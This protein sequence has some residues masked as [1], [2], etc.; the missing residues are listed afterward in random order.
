MSSGL[1]VFI[2][3]SKDL[4]SA[5][6]RVQFA[7]SLGVD[8][9]FSTHIASRDGLMTL[10]A[11]AA[12]TSTIKLGTGVLP[13]F[14]RHP[15]SLAVEAATLDEISGGRLILGVGPSHKVTME[16]WYGIPLDR[17]FSQMREYVDVLRQVFT[18]GRAALDGEFYKVQYAFM[19]YS[20]RPDIPIYLS[21]L[22]PKMLAFVGEACEGTI[23]WSCM[24]PY[25]RSTVAPMIAGAAAKA[26]RGTPD[27]I[28]AIPTALTTNKAAAFEQLRGDFFVYMTLPFYRR[29]IA[30]SGFQD[31]I[32]A[33]DKALGSGDAP[34]AKTAMSDEMLE[35]FAAIGDAK[36]IA[37]KIGEYRD[38]GVT[39][40]ALGIAPAGDGWAGYEE[41]LKAALA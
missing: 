39:T 21:A 9:V 29:A 25:I 30:G 34:G 16:S 12:A 37:A 10:A 41:T 22:A 40:P 19:N 15:L 23:L 13:A 7:E 31:E 8:A 38:A 14:P 33:F 35:T 2:A 32:D 24:P 4:A 5:V 6:E 11:Y 26:G 36:Q 17:P 28:A 27:I 20:A 3:P 18:T 1:A